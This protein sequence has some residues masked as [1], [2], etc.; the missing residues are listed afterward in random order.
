MKRTFSAK[1]ARFEALRPTKIVKGHRGPLN[2]RKDPLSSMFVVH[3]IVNFFNTISFSSNYNIIQHP[4]FNDPHLSKI[5][6]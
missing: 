3:V 5:S 2:N 6:I 1:T 4:C